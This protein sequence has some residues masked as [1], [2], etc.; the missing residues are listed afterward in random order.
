MGLPIL[1][2]APAA[3]G[4]PAFLSHP[5]KL[6]VEV[7]SRCNLHCAMCPK[8]APGGRDHDGDMDD[9]TFARLAPAFP[10]LESLVLNGIGESLLHRGLER[11]VAAARR[12]MPAGA[13]I[14]FQTNGQLV[15]PARARSLVQAGVD[16]VCLSADAVAPEVFRALRAG[17]RQDAVEAALEALHAA[18]AAVGRPISLGVEFV[19]MKN[20]L[21][22]LPALVRWAARH[23]VSFVIVTHMLPYSAEM[24][25]AAAFETST[26]AARELFREWKARAAAEG[27]DITRYRDVFMRFRRSPDEERAVE[28]VSRMVKDAWSRGVTLHLGRL[29]GSDEHLLPRVEA[30]FAEAADAA[31]ALGIDLRLPASVPTRER[32]CDFIEGGSAFVSWDGGVHPCYFLWH[33][34]H[35]YVGGTSK[36]VAP[37]SFGTLRERDILDIWGSDA[38]RAFRGEVVRYEYPFCH[39]CNA[40]LCGDVRDEVVEDCHLGTVPC[41]ACMWCTGVFQCLQ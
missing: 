2:H 39:D 31:R 35:C 32:R 17:G 19:A 7:T 10:R 4:G 41:A 27:V 11:F 25:G 37:Q 40:A 6:F 1:Q 33:K 15:T 13:W 20:N 5:S 22:E 12:D 34:Y 28:W 38:W 24:A 16:R 29:F 21:A 3:G 14:G 9:A 18:S 23:H 36:K 30:A 8:Q 26:D